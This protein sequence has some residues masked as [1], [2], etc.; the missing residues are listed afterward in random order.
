[1]TYTMIYHELVAKEDMHVREALDLVKLAERRNVSVDNAHDCLDRMVEA[2]EDKY[3]RLSAVL[4]AR[5][6]K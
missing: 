3:P 5:A 2:W 4:K 1:M 6:A